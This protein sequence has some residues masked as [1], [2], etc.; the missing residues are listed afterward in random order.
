MKLYLQLSSEY[1]LNAVELR[2]EKER[3]RPS[4]WSWDISGQIAGEISNFIQSFEFSGAHLPFI[5]LNPICPNPHI[6]EGSIKQLKNGIEKASQLGMNYVVM[7]ARGRIHGSAHEQELL[8]WTTVIG[9]LTRYAQEQNICLA[10]ENAESLSDL[11]EVV[12]IVR[13]IDSPN[14][15]IMLDIGHAYVRR[16]PSLS[17]YPVKEAMLKLLD[18][19]FMPFIIKKYMPFDKYGS[20]VN[21]IKREHD[22]IFGLH[23]HD[24]NGRKDHLTIGKG[25][26]DFSFLPTL[27]NEGFGGILILEMGF[28]SH[29]SDFRLNFQRLQELIGG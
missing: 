12:A 28:G 8:E 21:F 16:V 7:H 25:K 15:K 17:S 6:R 14:L 22:L 23:I 26:V 1:G 19:T 4:I 20:L 18:R 27:K 11:E 13:R 29:Y 5:Y 3:E 2:F 10:L 9:E 24:N